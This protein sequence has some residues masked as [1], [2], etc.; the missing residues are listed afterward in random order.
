MAMVLV[1]CELCQNETVYNLSSKTVYNLSSKTRIISIILVVADNTFQKVGGYASLSSAC[2][3]NL[4]IYF[5]ICTYTDILLQVLTR[6]QSFVF[7]LFLNICIY[8]NGILASSVTGTHSLK[9]KSQI[10]NTVTNTHYTHWLKGKNQRKKAI[11]NTHYIIMT[12]VMR[13]TNMCLWTQHKQSKLPTS[14]LD[15]MKGRRCDRTPPPPFTPHT[16]HTIQKHTSI[17]TF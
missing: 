13:H 16:R 15:F 7:F 9:G 3:E 6:F 5:I 10:E 11:T 8:V 4:W 17:H 2:V 1:E 12:D 14:D